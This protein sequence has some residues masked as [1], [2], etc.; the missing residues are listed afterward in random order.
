EIR[1]VVTADRILTDIVSTAAD[2]SIITADEIRRSGAAN[3]VEL[4]EG[5]PGVRFT[6]YSGEAQATVDIRGFGEGAGSRVLVL[7][8]GRRRNNPDLSGINWLG[9]PIDSIER[10]EI[11]RSGAS[12]LYGNNALGGV[13]NIIT[14][15]A[16]EPFSVT[17]SGVLGSFGETGSRLGISVAEENA[18]LR[19]AAE[20]YTTDGYRDRTA[21]DARNI[22]LDTEFDVLPS[23]TL[24]LD[25][26]HGDI[27]YEM[28]GSLT[29]EQFEDDPTQATNDADEARE[30]Q[31]DLGAGIVW[32]PLPLLS[33]E[34]PFSYAG[35]LVENDTASSSSYTDRDLHTW[36]TSPAVIA[37]AYVG[38]VPFRGRLGF[39]WS[40]ARQ[41]IRSYSDVDRSSRTYTALL[42][43]ETLGTV[44]SGTAYV[45]EQIDLGG[46]VRYD[47]ATFTAEKE[48]S[49]IDEQKTHEAVVFDLEGVFRPVEFA[50]IYATGGTLFR[51]PAL[52]EQAS[53]QGFGDRFEDDL[54]P[55][56]GVTV[57]VGGGLY[58]GPL[59]ELDVAGWWLA[60]EDEIA[61]V[62]DPVTFE[63]ANEN[64]EETTR[65]GADVRLTSEPIDLFRLSGGYSYV[66]AT[67]ADGDDKGNEVPLVP[68]HTVDGELA[69]RPGSALGL[70]FGPAVRYR[71]AAYQGGD[72][73]NEED[74]VSAHT[75]T[76]LFVRFRPVVTGDLSITAEV[77]NVFDTQYAPLQFY[78]SFSDSTGYYPAAGRSFRVSASYRY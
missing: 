41:T 16:D 29:E 65:T 43:Q 57:E 44:L 78:S 8:D 45:T 62:T 58:L 33:V 28:P 67:F 75:V 17:V 63:G 53:V 40:R 71:S 50:K 15:T 36:S 2:V 6:S 51:Y 52:D 3:V 56:R 32:T 35:R 23:V 30:E 46:T 60:M 13:I 69:L 25:G 21:Y 27:T 20:R 61:Y 9:I 49:D 76:D 70:E 55:E 4:L 19:A 11:V 24:N 66:M 22:S 54:D 37:D 7:V 18:R 47:R 39:D 72:D 26:H 42:G 77:K 48:S 1:V 12:A 31:I 38:S 59:V 73:A 64:I 14:K 34:V 5:H 10:I 68:N 74:R